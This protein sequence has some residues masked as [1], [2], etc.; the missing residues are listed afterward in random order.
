MLSL[1]LLLIFLHHESH[2]FPC[3]FHYLK[4]KKK[5]ALTE[6][7]EYNFSLKDNNIINIYVVSILLKQYKHFQSMAAS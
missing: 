1:F 3:L 6:R 7:L 4:K 5:L 2:T